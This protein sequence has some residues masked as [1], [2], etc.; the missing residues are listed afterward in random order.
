[1]DYHTVETISQTVALVFFFALF[2]AVCI[3]TF[4]PG[5]KKRFEKAAELPLKDNTDPKVKN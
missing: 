4:W 2:I 1:M 5:N 3:Y